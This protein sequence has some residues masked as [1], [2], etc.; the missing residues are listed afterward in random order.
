MAVNTSRCECMGGKN[1]GDELVQAGC[2]MGIGLSLNLVFPP[3]TVNDLSQ[4]YNLA[5]MVAKFL[6]SDGFNSISIH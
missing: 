4:Q 1:S 3:T 5:P 2:L 6:S